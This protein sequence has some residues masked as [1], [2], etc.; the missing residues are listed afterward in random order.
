MADRTK[1][2]AEDLQELKKREGLETT[3]NI[4]PPTDREVRLSPQIQEYLTQ[5][6]ESWEAL[7]QKPIIVQDQPDDS[8]PITNYFISSSHNTYLL[9][10][11]LLGRSS[12]LSYIHVLWHHARCIE[13]DVWSSESGPIVTHGYT[14]SK[15]VPFM[16]VC[17][18]VGAAVRSA[19]WPVFV[20]LEC[21]VEA[22]RQA[23]LVDIMKDCW[24]DKLITH[25]VVKERA[26][27]TPNDLRGR[28]VLMV[29][30]YPG[31]MI[32]GDPENV[33]ASP[34]PP[35]SIHSSAGSEV[36]EEEDAKERE[37]LEK[38]QK[39]QGPPKISDALAAL[40]VYARSMKPDKQ[41]LTEKL[42]YPVHVLINISESAISALLPTHLDPLVQHSQLHMRRVYPRGTRI[43]SSNMNPVKHWRSGSQITAV[44]WQK[45]DRGVQINEAMFAGT[46]GWVVKP[47]ALLPGY[48]DAPAKVTVKCSIIGLSSLPTSHDSSV[49]VYIQAQLFHFTS[50]DEWRSKTVQCK[51]LKALEGKADLTWEES[52]EFT[53]DDDEL[54]FLRLNV[55]E[56]VAFGRDVKM[57]VFVARIQQLE[58]GFRFVRLLDTKGKDTGATLLVNFVFEDIQ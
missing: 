51:D 11:Q 20:S 39:S 23:Q 6:G 9:S 50:T 29:E 31:K 49:S 46:P 55:V 16:E 47:A 53:Y 34:S 13:M 5:K 24:G 41:W 38:E 37:R 44:N 12:A 33:E 48:G 40:G 54:A 56:D 1:A 15:S 3:I 2:W 45:Y 10:R 8:L 21:H 36:E 42:N 43:E 27:I 52:F 57:A 35:Q 7:L 18:A 32:P 25:E 28:I 14:L 58:E 4:T 30:Y 19:D 22:D 17:E 26:D